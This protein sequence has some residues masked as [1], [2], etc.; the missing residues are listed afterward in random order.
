MKITF[1][2]A[3]W[4]SLLL[5]TG[6]QTAFAQGT[7]QKSYFPTSVA[8]VAVDSKDVTGKDVKI[9]NGNVT[10]QYIQA[11]DENKAMGKIGESNGSLFRIVK[12]GKTNIY[13]IYVPSKN[14]WLK[15][16]NTS[17]GPAKIILGDEEY[18]WTI[19]NNNDGSNATI[20]DI[21][22]TSVSATY[23][24]AA[25]SWNFHGGFNAHPHVGLYDANDNNSAWQLMVEKTTAQL[26]YNYQHN[27]QTWKTETITSAI[28]S[29]FPTSNLPDG[30]QAQWP[31]GTVSGDATKNINV[32][33]N[34]D[35]PFE[36]KN[37][38][39]AS[40][41]AYALTLKNKA[42]HVNGNDLEILSE[43]A[44]PD[45]VFR[46]VGDPFNGFTIY[47]KDN[48]MV[49]GSDK[50]TNTPAESRVKLVAPSA[51]AA[52]KYI[53]HI[54]GNNYFFRA[55]ENGNAFINDRD[56]SGKEVV[57]YWII[58]F[59]TVKND[60]GSR[61]TFQ[62]KD[63]LLAAQKA[64]ANKY[65]NALKPAATQTAVQAAQTAITAATDKNELDAALLTFKKTI[66]NAKVYLT[67]TRQ[68]N[69]RYVTVESDGTL[70]G[71]RSSP[72]VEDVILLNY[73]E[74]TDAYTLRHA[75]TGRF[76]G[77]T[78]ADN[79]PTPTTATSDNTYLLEL[80]GSRLSLMSKKIKGAHKY[81]HLG[82]NFVIM[83]WEAGDGGSSNASSWDFEAVTGTPDFLAPAQTYVTTVAGILGSDYHQY[84]GTEVEA[85]VEA[86]KTQKTQEN[87]YAFFNAVFDHPVTFNLPQPGDFFRIASSDAHSFVSIAPTA[88][89]NNLSVTTDRTDS[90]TVFYLDNNHK[91]SSFAQGR[92]INIKNNLPVPAAYSATDCGEAEFRESQAV[93]GFYNV[94]LSDK[95]IWLGSG[96]TKV[97]A[98][99]G[100]GNGDGT[101]S[102]ARRIHLERVTE[103]PVKIGAQ[104][105]ATFYAP[106]PMKIDTEHKAYVGKM[107]SAANTIDLE[108]IN[109]IIPAGTAFIITGT[110]ASNA[111]LTPVNEAGT[112]VSENIFTGSTLPYT[113]PTGKKGFVLPLKGNTFVPYTAQA[114]RGFRS[115]LLQSVA[116]PTRAFSLPGITGI[117][118]IVTVSPVDTPV[119][120][121]QGRRVWNLESGQIYVRNGEKFIQQ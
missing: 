10:T 32:T 28:G 59:N 62:T 31:T 61:I 14:K 96:A 108:E 34:A 37:T 83:A 36:F 53:L 42:L 23:K 26:T 40:Q 121:L 65:V 94:K 18:E 103:L 98:S 82:G 8:D 35:Y 117:T 71:K 115:V 79:Q 64:A 20:I 6:A 24:P 102:E 39:E 12:T 109:G 88:D 119:Y 43:T 66:Q 118:Q 99:N 78:V 58:D 5:A 116:S 25:A 110:P 46:F 101:G 77:Q 105:F 93:S 86:L 76:F 15:A 57:A 56:L 27:G 4:V 100:W 33:V 85:A 45:A 13:K 89:G 73:D 97:L 19:V 3:L 30:V 107:A 11:S 54:D 47:A 52:R 95:V 9:R 91:I 120:D 69:K 74:A 113:I 7:P 2:S 90:N 44:E 114:V 68:T 17:N 21:I 41:K 84:S 87:Y 50:A 106:V 80:A 111:T 70:F 60:L 67:A 1:Y 55:A 29:N 38:Y 92:G 51:A 48:T 75:V 104:G 63:A 22:P 81:L 16:S 72:D 112:P 49:L